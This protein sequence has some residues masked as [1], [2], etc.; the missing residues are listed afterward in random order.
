MPPLLGPFPG[1]LL[2]LLPEL[3][4][5][6]PVPLLLPM[7]LLL[8][9]GM[10]TPLMALGRPDVR[11]VRPVGGGAAATLNSPTTSCWLKFRLWVDNRSVY[12][13]LVSPPPLAAS[14]APTE[15]ASL[16]LGLLVDWLVG[17][18]VGWFNLGLLLLVSTRGLRSSAR[19]DI[20]GVGESGPPAQSSVMLLLLNLQLLLLLGSTALRL[21]ILL[22][23]DCSGVH[24]FMWVAAPCPPLLLLLAN[25]ALGLLKVGGPWAVRAAA[26]GEVGG[27]GPWAVWAAA[28]GEVGGEGPPLLV[29]AAARGELLGVEGPWVWA[30]AEGE[31]GVERPQL[32]RAA[33]RSGDRGGE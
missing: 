28:E 17:W 7:S 23:D 33:A 1:L 24:T 11:L 19:G 9:L 4:P 20:G 13:S 29:C 25:A 16:D 15:D 30:G 31:V 18:L 5:R 2:L 14:S 6:T 10:L 3:L 12:R 32:R 21:P 22:L 27:E 26:R 8:F